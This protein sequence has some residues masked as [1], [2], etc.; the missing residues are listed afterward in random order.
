MSY[1]TQPLPITWPYLTYS[2]I[3][4]NPSCGR[5]PDTHTH[6]HLKTY[7]LKVLFHSILLTYTH[8]HSWMQNSDGSALSV[9]NMSGWRTFEVWWW[10]CTASPP[11]TLCWPTLIPAMVTSF[12]SPTTITSARLCSLPVLSSGSF[13][14]TKVQSF[15]FTHFGATVLWFLCTHVDILGKNEM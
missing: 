4:P 3:L 7:T 8:T 6:T 14:S 2:L 12:P 13:Y 11:R 15:L 1:L 5:L 9:T 10:C